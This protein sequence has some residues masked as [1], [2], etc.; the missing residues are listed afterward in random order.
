MK[1][2]LIPGLAA[3]ERVFRH[4]HLPPNFEAVY[5]RWL[6]PI[7]NETLPHYALRMAGQINTSEPFSLIGL[8]FGGM[9][10]TEIARNFS[11]RQIIL[12]SSIPSAGHL[13]HY[14]KLAGRLKLHRLLPI[15]FIKKAALLKRHFTK[16]SIEDKNMLRCMIRDSDAIFIRWALQ[17]VL[18]WENT[19]IPQNL[20]HLHGT[21]DE[22]LPTRYTRPTHLIPR[23][24]HLM[25]MN[26]SEEINSF[27]EEVLR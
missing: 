20:F 24:G 27:L 10:A 9:I 7:I 16:E 21:K 11:A 6:P 18:A 17:A 1:V 26:R 13:P 22:I 3:D 12:I 14:Y 4:I 8:S 25:I 2:Y 5:L 23:G 19:L 15:T